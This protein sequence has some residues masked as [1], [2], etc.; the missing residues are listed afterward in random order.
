MGGAPTKRLLSLAL[1]AIL[2][3]DAGLAPSGAPVPLM[4]G[5]LIDGSEDAVRPAGEAGAGSSGETVDS[6]GALRITYRDLSL[7]G[8]DVDTMLDYLL[9]PEEFEGE[10][11]PE[12]DLPERITRL[13]NREVSIVGYMIPGETEGGEVADFMLVR[14]LASCCF[15]GSPMPDEWIDVVMV[16]GE[17]AEYHPFLPMRTRGVLRLGGQQDEVG[18]AVG[19]YRLEA[20]EVGVEE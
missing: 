4:R 14:D 2:G 7:E 5:A 19:I 13:A 15:G 17:T 8:Y 11:I 1:L 12:L 18:F 6:D 16:E 10:E 9:F 20:V 3:C